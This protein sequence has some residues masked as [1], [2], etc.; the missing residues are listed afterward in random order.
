M[1]AMAPA[2]CKV[3]TIL[4]NTTC[5]APHM[6]SALQDPSMWFDDSYEVDPFLPSGHARH[7]HVLP[8]PSHYGNTSCA[9]LR[10][11]HKCALQTAA[12]TEGLH[13]WAWKPF[14]CVLHP[15]D[16]DEHGRITLDDTP[17][18]LVE[19]GSCMVS[20]ATPIPL[21]I[22]FEPELRYLLG[23]EV[24]SQLIVEKQ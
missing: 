15:L 16:L 7:S 5:I 9:F 3:Q 12:I 18:L 11:D 13:P 24:Y 6:P 23:D 2:A 19:P 21:C 22:T 17:L 4:E 8:D 1:N 20:H 10:D 14:Y